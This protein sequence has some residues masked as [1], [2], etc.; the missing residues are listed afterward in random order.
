M[1]FTER[2]VKH[3]EFGHLIQEVF[4]GLPLLLGKNRQ[5]LTGVEAKK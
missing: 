5:Q 3:S 2:T 1:I 4:E